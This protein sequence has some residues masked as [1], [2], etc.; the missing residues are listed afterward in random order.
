MLDKSAENELEED[1]KEETRK[2]ARREAAG[3]SKDEE[4]VEMTQVDEEAAEASDDEEDLMDEDSDAGSEDR[5]TGS[6]VKVDAA[7]EVDLEAEKGDDPDVYDVDVVAWDSP[8]SALHLA[9]IGGHQEVIALLVDTYGADA[10]LPVKLMTNS[11][12]REPRGAILTLLLPLDLPLRRA[13]STITMLLKKG[14]SPVQALA[15]QTTALHLVVDQA[16]VEIL[17]TFRDA[18]PEATSKA[19][20]HLAVKS[21]WNGSVKYPLLSAI[22]SGSAEMVRE[23][24]SMGAKAF[25]DLEEYVCAYNATNESRNED[26][27][28]IEKKYRTDVTQ[29][30]IEAA[31]S[32]EMIDI[33]LQL[34]KLGADVNTVTE[35][36]WKLVQEPRYRYGS[37]EKTL[38]DLI[39][40]HRQELEQFASGADEKIEPLKHVEP[41]QSDDYYLDRLKPGTY[42]H[43][44]ASKDLETARYIQEERAKKYQR[45]FDAQKQAQ[46]SAGRQERMHAAANL[47]RKYKTVENRL[48]EEGAK[49]FYD[50]FPHLK[51]KEDDSQRGHH[52]RDMKDLDAEAYKTRFQFRGT[53]ITPSQHG[54]YLQ[55]FEA[56]FAGDIDKVK[57]MCM[58]SSEGRPLEAAVIDQNDFSLFAIAVFRGHLDVASTILDIAA[59]QYKHPKDTSQMHYSAHPF[60]SE[61]DEGSDVD[62]SVASDDERP[63]FYK[64]LV[65]DNFTIDDIDA[66]SKDVKSKTKPLDLLNN[67]GRGFEVWRA[68]PLSR[69]QA[70][71][72]CRAAGGFEFHSYYHFG[73]RN[74]APWSLFQQSFSQAG[75]RAHRSIFTYAVITNN[76]DLMKFLF[77]VEAKYSTEDEDD[78]LKSLDSRKEELKHAMNLG[79]QQIVDTILRFR[80]TLLPLH[81]LAERSGV[82]VEEAPKYYQ[83]LS[84]YGQKR[85]DWAKQ[86]R[87]ADAVDKGETGSPLLDAIMD[88]N[89]DIIDYFMSETPTRR[90]EEFSSR[91]K[92]D[93]RVRAL[94]EGKG[95]IQAALKMWMSTRTNLALHIAVMAWPAG[96]SKTLRYLLE[97]VPPEYLE[98][99]SAAGDTPLHLALKLGNLPAMGIL[100]AAGANQRTRD[101][102]GQNLLHTI[103]EVA[104]SNEIN[105]FKKK[106]S[107]LD[108]KIIPSLLLE[109][110]SGTGPGLLTPLSLYL[111][112]RPDSNDKDLGLIEE[113][114]RISGGKDLTVMDGAGDYPLHV[115]VRDNHRVTAQYLARQ[116]PDL[117]FRENATGMTPIEVAETRYLQSVCD[118]EPHLKGSVQSNGILNQRDEDFEKKEAGWAPASMQQS[119]SENDDDD[120]NLP[121]SDQ[122]YSNLVRI[123]RAHPQPRSLVSVLDANEVARRLAGQQQRKNAEERARQAR[124][125][126]SRRWRYAHTQQDMYDDDEADN[127]KTAEQDEVTRWY[128]VASERMMKVPVH[129]QD[130][131]DLEAQ[132]QKWRDFAEGKLETLSCCDKADSQDAKTKEGHQK[133]WKEISDP[134]V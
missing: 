61:D 2:Q 66:L 23:V 81:H 96:A 1:K 124:G 6:F 91:F 39:R 43:W 130:G 75:I 71:R 68:L 97:K 122:G 102:K 47:A 84:V 113:M 116:R 37:E 114:L 5:M 128:S 87:Y 106:V 18:S 27:E 93:Q 108:K 17:K 73:R 100:L 32:E 35:K 121:L 13:T 24:L 126:K 52:D 83:G 63:R 94:A 67:T 101:K 58:S 31:R 80:G 117:L 38:L 15:D 10:M 62:S 107:M 82:V 51:E 98:V 119:I 54:Q 49:S 76:A 20:N 120:D 70:M 56:V 88:G 29:P 92:Q 60:D 34:L 55:L 133:M 109:R 111:L 65:N 48:I 103:W 8:C 25:I 72:K 40:D 95:G 129:L 79:Y 90:Y 19:I 53:N 69:E 11:I 131:E 14:A 44:S 4:D 41:L 59:A 112:N 30:V 85:K 9:I 118:H 89:I 64:R 125:L 45:E 134:R 77:E 50:L 132:M 42:Q 7:S 123:A 3:V 21:G 36:S 127:G 110:C 22:R 12:P 57:E 105:L 28:Q 26:P 33:V 74:S 86:D 46:P 104:R 99:R 16:K 115:Q 78:L